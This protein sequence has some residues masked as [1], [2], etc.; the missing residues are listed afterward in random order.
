[1]VR[2]DSTC[3]YVPAEYVGRLIVFT[4]AG[5]RVGAGTSAGKAVNCPSGGG[6]VN[7]KRNSPTS[8]QR[9]DIYAHPNDFIGTTIAE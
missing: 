2:I 5:E 8:G 4:E 9:Y 6:W 1:M 7:H 3:I